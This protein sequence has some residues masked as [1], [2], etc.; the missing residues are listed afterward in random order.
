MYR[1]YIYEAF[2]LVFS[3]SVLGMGIGLV[4]SPHL[5]FVF[6]SKPVTRVDCFLH[7]DV[8]ADPLHT[9][10]RTLRFPLG[11]PPHRLR[12]FHIF[13]CR[14]LALPNLSRAQSTRCSDIPRGRLEQSSTVV[15]DN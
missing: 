1:V 4:P 6:S 9:A 8:A 12:L 14:F 2:V 7:D 11:D 13:R 3:A 5:H 10:S 15:D